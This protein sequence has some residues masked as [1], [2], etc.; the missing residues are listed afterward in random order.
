MAES[1]GGAEELA[2]VNEQ[3]NDNG[4]PPEVPEISSMNAETPPGGWTLN[5]PNY[6]ARVAGLIERLLQKLTC[7]LF[8]KDYGK[9]S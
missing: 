1:L 4:T 7:T 8:W 3:Q 5:E 2:E 6:I 9:R